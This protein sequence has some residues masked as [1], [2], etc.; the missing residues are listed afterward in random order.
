MQDPLTRRK[1]RTVK[2]AFLRDVKLRVWD[3]GRRRHVAGSAYQH[4]FIDG[5]LVEAL[6]P[7]MEGVG[8]ALVYK[9]ETHD[10]F[11]T[12]TGLKGR[13][14]RVTTARAASLS[15]GKIIAYGA[16]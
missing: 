5:L 11:V 14:S 12:Q 4:S 16:R 15:P 7:G 3:S 10:S 1:I 13:P 9:P 8:I 6:H 2:Q